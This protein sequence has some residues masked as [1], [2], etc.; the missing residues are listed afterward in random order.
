MC[1]GKSEL[2][3]V[4][5]KIVGL[6]GE[7]N[8]VKKKTAE[9]DLQPV[10]NPERQRLAGLQEEKNLLQQRLVGLQEEKNLLLK[11]QQGRQQQSDACCT[12][13]SACA[14]SIIRIRAADMPGLV[15][16][17][18][19]DAGSEQQLPELPMCVLDAFPAYTYGTDMLLTC[20][21]TALPLLSSSIMHG[22][23]RALMETCAVL[24]GSDG[25][26]LGFDVLVVLQQH[27][28]H[29]TVLR[30]LRVVSPQPSL[31][32][33]CTPLHHTKCACKPCR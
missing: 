4:R 17:A 16:T 2:Q 30:R 25:V 18:A 7:L 11:A 3:I 12:C 27:G 19:D 33:S 9:L 21:S 14:S 31:A 6:E 13:C 29:G 28:M 20:R 5:E 24:L 1:A 15:L 22:L 32:A 10:S 8:V 26:Q 23:L